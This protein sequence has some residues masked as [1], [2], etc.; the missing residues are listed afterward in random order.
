MRILFLSM[1]KTG[2]VQGMNS[3]SCSR[4]NRNS[5]AEPSWES[6]RSKQRGWWRRWQHSSCFT[7]M[8]CDQ[9]SDRESKHVTW[10]L[11]IWRRWSWKAI[12]GS[13]TR[14]WVSSELLVSFS[15][16]SMMKLTI[17]C[18]QSDHYSGWWTNPSIW[19]AIVW[20]SV[21]KISLPVRKKLPRM[22]S[23]GI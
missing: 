2:W 1:W 22:C 4:I 14:T 21:A 3:S 15:L 7:S 19:A 13:R 23:I 11:H 17:S 12:N 18:L 10:H 8:N 9:H 16:Q 20:S 5:S 6:M